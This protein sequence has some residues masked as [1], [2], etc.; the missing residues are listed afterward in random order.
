MNHIL[1]VHHLFL[2]QRCFSNHVWKEGRGIW[3]DRENRLLVLINED[4]HIK[5][6]C[7]QFGGDLCEVFKRLSGFLLR[8]ERLLTENGYQFVR[9]NHY[10]YLASRPQEL[11]TSLR[12]SVNVNLPLSAKVR[13]VKLGET[14]ER[15]GAY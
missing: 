2:K 8:L 6:I 3:H 10:G 14:I 15:K 5:I 4:E 12:V 11:G 13:M 9:N 1:H 7:Q